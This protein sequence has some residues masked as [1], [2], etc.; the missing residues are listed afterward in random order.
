MCKK[1]NGGA[2]KFRYKWTTF[3]KSRLNCSVPGNTPFYFNDIQSTT[4]FIQDGQDQV[5]YGVFNTPD[6]SIAGSAI[7]AFKLSDITNA[8]EVGS[9]KNQDT[10]NSNWLP[11]SRSQIP[12]PRPGI[13]SNDSL[14]LSEAN[15][16]FVKRHSLVDWA[17][18]GAT[19][20]PI[21]TKT[22]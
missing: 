7:C 6:N 16:N 4:N 19:K 9:F 1:D 22:R 5:V 15:L 13:C 21:F 20:A 11:M 18:Q 12:E 14:S 10:S 3:L 17:V 8:F 2:H